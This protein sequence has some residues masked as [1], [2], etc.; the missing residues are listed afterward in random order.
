MKI[1]IASKETAK[2]HID[3]LNGVGYFDMLPDEDKVRILK[4]DYNHYNNLDALTKAL[5]SKGFS[6]SVKSRTRTKRFE[7]Y[8]FE[9]L[10]NTDVV[11]SFG[12]D[13]EAIDMARNLTSKV[14]GEKIPLLWIEKSDNSSVGALCT[15]DFDYDYKSILVDNGEY[16]VAKWARAKGVVKENGRIIGE[17]VALNEVSFGDRYMMGMARYMLEYKGHKEVQRSSGGVVST[18]VGLLGWLLNIPTHG[19]VTN[20]SDH[21]RLFYYT[22]FSSPDFQNRTMEFRLREPARKMNIRY[23]EGLIRPDEKIIITSMMNSDGIVSFDGSKPHYTNP[24]T[25][26]F[27]LGRTLEVMASDEPLKVLRF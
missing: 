17:D 15:T 8:S 3:R 27:N 19:L 22:R 1:L 23:K 25:Y 20:F 6:V 4:A 16:R 26:D 12:G 14:L 9:D 11:I 24:R 13:G 21:V 5:S 7:S 18:Q 2:E 10:R